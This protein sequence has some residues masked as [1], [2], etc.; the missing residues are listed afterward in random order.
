MPALCQV[1]GND[2]TDGFGTAWLRLRMT[3]DPAVKGLELLGSHGEMNRG[4]IDARASP[5]SLVCA[6]YSCPNH[7]L[8]V[9]EKTGRSKVATLARRPRPCQLRAGATQQND[10]DMEAARLADEAAGSLDLAN[11]PSPS[12]IDLKAEIAASFS[13]VA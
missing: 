9:Q 4:R 8:S 6:R 13:E 12:D 1:C 10:A 7:S 5:A 11:E 2:L 3:S